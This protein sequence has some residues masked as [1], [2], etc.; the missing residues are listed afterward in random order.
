M[1]LILGA[2]AGSPEVLPKSGGPVQVSFKASTTAGMAQLTATYTI[3]P[4]YPYHF[5]NPPNPLQP[6]QQQLEKSAV[7]T[8]IRRYLKD[9][10][11]E[12]QN[13]E[14]VEFVCVDLAV[15]LLA[16]GV[17]LTE[18]VCF[19]VGSGHQLA[20]KLKLHRAAQGMT[21][22]ALADVLGLSR[23]TISRAERGHGVLDATLEQLAGWVREVS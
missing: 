15:S 11:L 5:A 8:V 23:S 16:G 18:S 9:M 19:A 14:S 21:Q 3:P 22:A 6:R 17:P 7:S 4:Q 12:R 20:T 13:G 2:V 1:E 10:V